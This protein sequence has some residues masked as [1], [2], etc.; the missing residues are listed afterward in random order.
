MP[1]NNSIKVLFLGDIVGKPGR[2]A[3]VKSL[4]QIKQEYKPDITIANAENLAHGIG[5]TLKTFEECLRAGI[6]LM[7]SGNH[8][9]GKPDANKIFENIDS[10]LL[11]PANYPDQTP[12]QGQKTLLVGT[13]SL[14]VINLNG[15]VFIEDERGFSCPFKAIDRILEQYDKTD[16]SGII[17]DFHAEATSEK[18]AFGWYVDGR[19]SAVLGTHTHIPTADEKIMPQGTAYI[20]DVGMVGLKESVI[21]IDKDIIIKKFLTQ[22]PITHD[23]PDKGPCLINAVLVTIDSTTKKTKKIERIYKEIIV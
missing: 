15:R 8:I 17:V 16:L 6:D 4:P 9:W 2:K 12:G 23:I 10:P 1:D 7:T 14:L 11:R 22:E 21:G 13:K 3:L 18:V 19:I 20:T 5:I